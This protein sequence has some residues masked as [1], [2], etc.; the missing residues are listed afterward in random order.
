MR[1]PVGFGP[2]RKR[3]GAAA[4]LVGDRYW[5]QPAFRFVGNGDL[6][7]LE[8]RY[9]HSGGSVLAS[10]SDMSLPFRVGH[11]ISIRRRSSSPETCNPDSDLSD[12]RNELSESLRVHFVELGDLVSSGLVVPTTS[13]R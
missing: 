3:L 10:L 12:L 7:R 13:T 5:S 1:E 8:G 4:S 11:W 9:I 2:V 6:A